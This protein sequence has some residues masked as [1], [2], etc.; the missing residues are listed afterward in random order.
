[1]SEAQILA[2][3]GSYRA[4]S[5]EAAAVTVRPRR[6][7]EPDEHAVR[8]RLLAV[9]EQAHT[10]RANAQRLAIGGKI[11]DELLDETLT[12]T[13]ERIKSAQARLDRLHGEEVAL[14][15]AYVH[16]TLSV[17]ADLADVLAEETVPIEGRRAA[18]RHTGLEAIYINRPAVSLEFRTDSH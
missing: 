4:E 10:E 2:A 14:P 18:L 5:S 11:S 13:V 3:L 16:Q 7:G 12:D 17:M 6:A 8:A 9:V 15:D 1:M